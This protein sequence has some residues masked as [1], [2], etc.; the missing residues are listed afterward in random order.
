WTICLLFFQAALLAGYA[1]AHL[2]V[3]RAPPRRGVAIHLGLVAL[4]ALLLPITPSPPAPGGDPALG[5]LGVLTL[6]VGGPFLVLSATAP[7][8]QAWAAGVEHGRSPYRLYAWSNAGSL[9]AL[10]AYPLVLE[11]LLGLR[12]QAWAWTA[13]YG[14][15]ALLL[16][17]CGVRTWRADAAPVQTAPVLAEEAPN[18]GG[19]LH[20]IVL[21]LTSSALLLATTDRLTEDISAS[22]FLWVL[23]LG[24]YLLSYILAFGRP[25]LAR[26]GVW[27]PLLAAA[28]VGQYYALRNGA[29]VGLFGQLALLNGGLFVGC[30]VLHGEV[31]RLRPPASRLTGFYLAT[32]LGGALGGLLVGVVAPR[33]LPMRVELHLAMVITAALGV[34]AAWRGWRARP[35]VSL[36]GWLWAGPMAL[37]VWLG[38][39]LGLLLADRLEDA[40]RVERGFYGVLLVRDEMGLP[41]VGATRSLIH[42]RILHGEQFVAEDRRDEPITYYGP[43]SGLRWAFEYA[44]ATA[45]RPLRVAAIGL[46]VGTVAAHGACGDAIDFY[47]IDPLVERLARTWFTYLNDTC[48]AVRVILGD[49]RLSLDDATEHYDLIVLDAFSSDAIPTHLLTREAIAIYLAHLTEGG[50]IV[51]NLSNRHLD[52]RPVMR[53]HAAHFGL[54]LS[55]VTSSSDWMRG[56]SRARWALLIGRPG[57]R[58]WLEAREALDAEEATDALD[59]TDDFA[60]QLPLLK[61][62]R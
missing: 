34:Q 6:G 37:V 2:L 38:V 48:A 22:P 35:F 41:E 23:P 18:A 7:L 17:L 25:G 24:L 14:V 55:E 26:R 28:L 30:M 39:G 51:A 62:L 13:G 4:S 47:E 50:Q 57:L 8:V 1:H 60:P 52:L 42:G 54:E 36:P 61:A 31:V 9:L 15:Y 59:W 49:G 3:L 12:Q 29:D 11:P 19:P 20:W 46:G 33:V 32:A 16:G 5:I 53:A 44:R 45:G 58:K 21:T 27:I 43:D 56:Y 10:L 40:V